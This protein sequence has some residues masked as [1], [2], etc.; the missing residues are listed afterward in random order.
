MSGAKPSSMLRISSGV[1]GAFW[2][3]I[4][5]SRSADG[6]ALGSGMGAPVARAILRE[7][8]PLHSRQR[9]HEVGAE[10][11]GR[12]LEAGPHL[13]REDA[14]GGLDAGEARRLVA[15]RRLEPRARRTAPAFHLR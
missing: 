2:S 5:A 12:R 3:I 1:F 15:A 9:Q 7:I 8:V 13:A 14:A 4:C 10:G 6:A 11:R